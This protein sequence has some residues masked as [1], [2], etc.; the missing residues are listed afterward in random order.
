MTVFTLVPFSFTGILWYYQEDLDEEDIKQKIGSLYLGLKYDN[1]FTKIHCLVYML[2]RSLF[3]LITFSLLKYPGIQ[4]QVFIYTGILYIIYLNHVYLHED[5]FASRL[6]TC[7]EFMLI[8]ICYHIVLIV[9]LVSDYEMK[10]MIG[11]SL[12]VMVSL[13]LAMNL[14]IMIGFSLE[15]GTRKL[16]LFYL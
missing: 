14:F 1:E 3:V 6:E 13:M 8:L 7:N 11:W 2:R 16:K 12:I 10:E 9:G 5:S 4:I 15:K